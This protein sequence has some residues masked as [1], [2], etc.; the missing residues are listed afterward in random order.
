MFNGIDATKRSLIFHLFFSSSHFQNKIQEIC[1][2]IIGWL[3]SKVYEQNSP[4][5]KEFLFNFCLVY[6]G[7]PTI[8]YDDVF[9]KF[10]KDLVSFNANLLYMTIYFYFISII[11][12]HGN[13]KYWKK[14]FEYT[15][16]IQFRMNIA[17]IFGIFKK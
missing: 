15:M 14:T 2:T 7:F 4:S 12:W 16:H 5:H 6:I 3:C 10:I 17:S 1:D 9:K 8:Y 11:V 13:G